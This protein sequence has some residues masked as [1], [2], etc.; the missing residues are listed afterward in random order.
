MDI[1]RDKMIEIMLSF[2]CLPYEDDSRHEEVH[3]KGGRIC[4]DQR[5]ITKAR[6][7]GKEMI[8]QIGK[9]ILSGSFNLTKVSFP[10][11]VMIP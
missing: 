5:I 11:R 10:I 2:N 1:P 9:K 7:V 4:A 6:S 8:K 3:P